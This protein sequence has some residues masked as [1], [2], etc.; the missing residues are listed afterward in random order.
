MFN[1]WSKREAE[2]LSEAKKAPGPSGT[3]RVRNVISPQPHHSAQ[4]VGLTREPPQGQAGKSTTTHSPGPPRQ[5]E[6]GVRI[7]QA[8]LKESVGFW[9]KCPGPQSR[10]YLGDRFGERDQNPGST[11]FG[12]G[13]AE[14]DLHATM[15]NSRPCQGWER[16]PGLEAAGRSSSFGGKQTGRA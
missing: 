8:D 13:E 15:R 4:V 5:Q 9:E 1:Q 7:G 10:L 14:Q 12:W 2:L 16:N 6:N 11:W 3:G